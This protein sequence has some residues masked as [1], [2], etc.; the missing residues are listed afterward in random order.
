MNKLL[1]SGKR[2]SRPA[3]FVLAMTFCW[4][5]AVEEPEFSGIFYALDGTKLVQLERQNVGVQATLG[6]M[7]VMKGKAA[8]KFPGAHSP[9]RLL[10]APS[11][12]FVVRSSSDADPGALYHL[13]RLETKNGEREVVILTERA[14][15]LGASAKMNEQS[16]VPVEYSRYGSSSV[17]ITAT[18]LPPGE[19]AIGARGGKTVFCF[20]VD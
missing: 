14:S 17:T 12:G 6:G 11:L 10:S 9:I 5:Q 16:I 2:I 15:P 7:M 20:G 19:Y 1:V 18:S 13:R 4:G 8:I 3:G